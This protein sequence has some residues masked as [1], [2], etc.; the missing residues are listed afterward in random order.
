MH[1]NLELDQIDIKGAYLNGEL[2]DDKI[3]YMQQ[4]PRYPYPNANGRVLQL[5][6]MIYGL[7][8]SGHQWYQKLMAI[9][10]ETMGLTRCNVNQA[11]FYRHSNLSILIMAI[12]IDDCTI[13]AHPPE[14]VVELKEKLG[15][16]V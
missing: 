10:K 13:A 8:Q 16:H 2:T 11:V 3:I 5:G 14:L 15:S 4:P 12:H 9:C 1:L 7:K 6:K